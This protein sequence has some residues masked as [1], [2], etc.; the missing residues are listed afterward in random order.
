MEFYT[1]KDIENGQVPLEYAAESAD[2]KENQVQNSGRTARQRRSDDRERFRTQKIS[3]GP[4]N[5]RED[6]VEKSETE[7]VEKNAL[8]MAPVHRASVTYPYSIRL[9]FPFWRWTPR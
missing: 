3:T 7:S 8:D 4:P 6:S 1:G 5:G 9:T 2:I